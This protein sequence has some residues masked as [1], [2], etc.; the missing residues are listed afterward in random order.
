[1]VLGQ[2]VALEM[3]NKHM[4]FHK[5]CFNT[6]KVIAKVKV[7]HNDDDNDDYYAAANADVTGVM[8]IPQL[9]FFDKQPS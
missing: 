1:M 6:Y 5:I 3:V 2:I 8:T 7:C 4:K 9:L